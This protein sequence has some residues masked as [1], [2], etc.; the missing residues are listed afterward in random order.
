MRP[1]PL[2]SLG[3]K[4]GLSGAIRRRSSSGASAS[5]PPKNWPTLPFPTLQVLAKNRLF[6][7]VGDLD[8]GE[9]FALPAEQELSLAGSAQ[10]PHPLRMTARGDEVLGSVECEQVDRCAARL[11]ALAATYLEQPRAPDADPVVSARRRR[12]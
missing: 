10:V 1:G 8:A 6:T 12:D 7:V 11:S 9:A 2:P 3:R 5:T 4:I